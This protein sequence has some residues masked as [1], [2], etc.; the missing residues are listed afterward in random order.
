M[1]R[2]IHHLYFFNTKPNLINPILSV[3]FIPSHLLCTKYNLCLVIVSHFAN[4]FV[5]PGE[6]F[7]LVCF[8]KSHV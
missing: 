2:I 6:G 4:I 7:L 3:Y 1:D 5:F 8:F